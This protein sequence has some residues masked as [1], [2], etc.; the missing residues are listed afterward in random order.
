MFKDDRG[1]SR[2]TQRRA[3]ASVKDSLGVSGISKADRKELKLQE[4]RAQ[5]AKQRE[6][7]SWRDASSS[8]AKKQHRAVTKDLAA[9]EKAER[10][11]ELRKLTEAESLASGSR[12]A[13]KK[14]QKKVLSKSAVR[15]AALLAAMPKPKSSKTKKAGSKG[16][17]AS[18]T[19]SADSSVVSASVGDRTPQRKQPT[20]PEDRPLALEKTDS[21]KLSASSSIL[22]LPSTRQTSGEGGTTDQRRRSTVRSVSPS[23]PWSPTKRYRHSDNVVPPIALSPSS[24]MSRESHFSIFSSNILTEEELD[25]EIGGSS[26][27]NEPDVQD[28]PPSQFDQIETP[29]QRGRH[30]KMSAG[31]GERP[32]FHGR[33]D[34]AH[35]DDAHHEV[36]EKFEKAAI[37]SDETAET[38]HTDTD[39]EIKLDFDEREHEYEYALKR[40]RDSCCAPCTIM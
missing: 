38:R 1:A 30:R 20:I 25:R 13:P 28:V 15:Q 32:A 33:A 34:A 24:L 17:K 16:S 5:V 36:N 21:T 3:K 37:V 39:G 40:R 6:E 12:A 14:V 18:E 35:D 31:T 19:P 10:K 23:A 22:D 2:D 7:A 26:S 29:L 9:M 27:K 11:Q 4:E 8:A